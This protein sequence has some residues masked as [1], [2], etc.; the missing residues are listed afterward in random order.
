MAGIAG[1]AEIVIATKFRRVTE[2]NSQYSI[3]DAHQPGIKE[4]EPGD[5]VS[6]EH[7][8]KNLVPAGLDICNR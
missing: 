7:G 8:I 6:F 2:I 1:H 3:S 5:T 4:G